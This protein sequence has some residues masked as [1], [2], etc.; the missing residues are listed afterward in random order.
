M[1][2]PIVHASLGR[3]F[4]DPFFYILLY[5]VPAFLLALGA[6][7]WRG[8]LIG[9]VSVILLA[10]V[11]RYVAQI[12]THRSIFGDW[13]AFSDDVGALVAWLAIPVVLSATIGL[14]TFATKRAGYSM[15]RIITVGVIIILA[16]SIVHFIADSQV[17]TYFYS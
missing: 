14:I 3:I 5:Y 4:V 7:R 15:D 8:A 11:V 16:A 12:T 6:R 1:I 2:Q 17:I 9:P 10:W 13:P